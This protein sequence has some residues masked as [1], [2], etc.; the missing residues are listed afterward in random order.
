M[1]SIVRN[2]VKNSIGTPLS[3]ATTTVDLGVVSNDGSFTSIQGFYPPLD[4]SINA[5]A[6]TTTAVG[7]GLWQVSGLPGNNAIID[8]SGNANTTH[9][10][11]TETAGGISRSYFIKFDDDLGDT[12]WA[13]DYTDNNPGITPGSRPVTIALQAGP[14]TLSNLAAALTRRDIGAVIDTSG[15]SEV[16]FDCQVTTAATGGGV[17]VFQYAS[18]GIT[19]INVAAI[20]ISAT[21]F[22]TSGYIPMPIGA[23]GQGIAFQVATAYGNG[24]DNP[25]VSFVSISY[26]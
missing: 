19:W 20:S 15:A 6:S 12:L 18:D 10:R 14:I 9:W 17:L 21:G 16:K 2:I 25:I 5:P 8:A 13:G 1:P 11:I 22:I 26:R 4:F 24:T 7:T 23:K 3:G